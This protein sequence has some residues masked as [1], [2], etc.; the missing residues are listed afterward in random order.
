MSLLWTTAIAMSRDYFH[1]TNRR[2]RPGEFITPAD[3][4]GDEV[5]WP[6]ITSTEHAYA[7]EHESDAWTYAHKGWEMRGGGHENLPRVY[8]VR[9]VDPHRPVEND[10]TH[11][12]GGLLRGV[13]DTDRRSPH[14]FEVIEE[15][16]LAHEDDY[17]EGG[18]MHGEHP[19]EGYGYTHEDYQES[20]TPLAAHFRPGWIRD[21][22]SYDGPGPGEDLGHH[23]EEWR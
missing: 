5:S 17:D 11:D 23:H 21:P 22:G 3:E 7:T 16:P 10:P 12:G 19:H 13:N 2:F 4:H 8:R 6:S 18:R 20:F 15:M 14:G 1:G 9:P